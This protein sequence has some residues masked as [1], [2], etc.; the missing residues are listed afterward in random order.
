MAIKNGDT[1]RVHYTGTLSDGTV[2]D[3]SRERDPLEF[4]MGKGMLIP[5][6]EAAVMGHEAGES[7]FPRPRLMAKA[8]PSW[9][10]P[11]TAP[12]CPIISR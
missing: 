7:P 3:S 8:I 1:L 4:T 9:S 11:W 5:G 10:S 12:R 6:F 2:F